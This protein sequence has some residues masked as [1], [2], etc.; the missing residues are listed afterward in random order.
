[1]QAIDYA[2]V[3]QIARQAGACI[4][5]FFRNDPDVL[6]KADS[7]PL[8]QADLAADR[9][10]VN[11]LKQLLGD[12]T[13]IVSEESTHGPT[14]E[15]FWLVDPL[16]GTKSFVAGSCEFTVNIA[17][18]RHGRPV[19]GVIFAPALDQC[20]WG[21]PGLGAFYEGQPIHVQPCQQPLRVLASKNHLNADTRAYLERLPEHVPVHSGSSLKFCTIAL[22]QADLYPRLGPCCEW[23]TGAGEAIL[24]G[25]GGS[26][27]DLQ[28]QELVYGK[29][30][31]LNP[32]FIA[33]GQTDPRHYLPQRQ[34]Q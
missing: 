22:G 19:W 8:T 28:G 2:R 29:S 18:I 9:C 27:C 24:M 14:A 1:M 31:P 5:P 30:D 3:I 6:T 13:S 17:L 10:I 33:S 25:A 11:G 26:I 32:H 34:D 4:L 20:W 23:D 7:S 16:D 15:V 12:D 21:G